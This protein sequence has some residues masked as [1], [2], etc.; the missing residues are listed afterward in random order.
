MGTEDVVRRSDARQSAQAFNLQMLL[1]NTLFRVTRHGWRMLEYFCWIATKLECMFAVSY[2]P[3]LL[4]NVYIVSIQKDSAQ[5]VSWPRSTS[6]MLERIARIFSP[7]ASYRSGGESGRDLKEESIRLGKRDGSWW[8]VNG[9]LLAG[10]ILSGK[11]WL[12]KSISRVFRECM[13][14][15]LNWC[16]VGDTGCRWLLNHLNCEQP[17][18]WMF[19]SCY[20]C[21]GYIAVMNRSQK[22]IQENVPIRQGLA[23]EQGVR[24]FVCVCVCWCVRR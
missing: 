3:W 22:D 18:W 6:W 23:K 16:L 19:V 20:V 14:G 11:H 8:R 7:T 5:L 17:P 21:R 1:S 13:R 2:T 9:R 10:E 12:S 24:V 4:G 15:Y